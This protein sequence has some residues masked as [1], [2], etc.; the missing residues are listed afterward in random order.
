MTQQALD[1]LEKALQ[2]APNDAN[3]LY[4]ATIIQEI[5]GQ[6]GL[7]LEYLQKSLSQGYPL[8]LIQGDP[9]LALLRKDSRY[10][11]LLLSQTLT[12]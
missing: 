8:N 2:L 5:I 9:E 1:A 6:R 7:A 11:E 4:R 10:R 12:N 3:I